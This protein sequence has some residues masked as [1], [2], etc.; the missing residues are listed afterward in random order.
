MGKLSADHRKHLRSSQFAGPNRTY[1]I[2]DKAHAADAKARAAQ[3]V[4]AG[5]LTPAAEKRID[6]R[7]NRVLYGSPKAPAGR[8]Q[9]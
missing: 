6:A 7:A 5:N 3:Q 4:K 1:P 2:P 8:K 9:S